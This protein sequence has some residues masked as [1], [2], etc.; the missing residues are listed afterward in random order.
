VKLTKEDRTT[1]EFTVTQS[2]SQP[3]MLNRM[4][5]K[6]IEEIRVVNEYREV[7]PK[8]LLGMPD[9]EIEF[10]IELLPGTPPI[11]KRLYRKPVNELAEL[12]K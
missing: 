7:F 5:G 10:I 6:T 2:A 4:E 12:M 11:S 3:S 8:E 1:I 9:R